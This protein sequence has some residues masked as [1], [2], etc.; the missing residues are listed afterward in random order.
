MV[1]ARK[2]ARNTKWYPYDQ[3]GPMYV[4]T[5]Y[6]SFYSNISMGSF[7]DHGDMLKAQLEV[8]L[9]MQEE[10]EN[11]IDEYMKQTFG[12][13]LDDFVEFIKTW[14]KD[15]KN[16]TKEAYIDPDIRG[17][18]KYGVAVSALYTPDLKQG[19][20]LVQE[21]V[22][23]V[24]NML[25]QAADKGYINLEN[26]ETLTEAINDSLAD[27][28]SKINN[29]VSVP[30][31][32]DRPV[33]V[34]RGAIFNLKGLIWEAFISAVVSRFFKEVNDREGFEL[35][36]TGAMAGAKADALQ[37]LGETSLPIS[38]K[39]TRKQV[40]Q[41]Y[42]IYVHHGT[43]KSILDII[44]SYSAA[45]APAVSDAKYYLINV[46][47]MLAHDLKAQA[48]QK[49]GISHLPKGR[50]LISDLMS[51]YMTVFIGGTNF[52]DDGQISE[53]VKQA[54]ILIT[55][56]QAFRKSFIIRGLLAGEDF[57]AY[58][59][60][61]YSHA[62]GD[63]WSRFDAWKR[64]IL[65]GNRGNYADNELLSFVRPQAER[66]LAQQASVKLRLLMK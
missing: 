52:P 16:H 40:F 2:E 3:L 59:K 21:T 47:R 28:E 17:Q 49:G 15:Y 8:A 5:N 62:S 64:G 12:K 51:T 57:A 14:F 36:A 19:L 9:T 25:Q 1:D 4:H 53:D 27:V 43:L 66:V 65:K 23:S 42:G 6:H 29:L 37:R 45:A 22:D 18:L 39:S 63:H 58:L 7:G 24:H 10:R 38:I 31:D 50:K 46:S 48:G 44:E 61:N 60:P 35:I 33:N 41:D 32:E 20:A 30:Q 56:D 11:K 55:Q 13:G 54:D 26:F 34:L